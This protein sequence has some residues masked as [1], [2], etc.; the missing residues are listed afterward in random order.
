MLFILRRQEM[1]KQHSHLGEAKWCKSTKDRKY[2]TMQKCQKTRM[3]HKKT[4]KYKIGVIS[5]TPKG[6]TVHVKCR[7][8]VYVNKYK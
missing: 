5:V 6:Y 8:R 4:T 2:T 1:R 3:G 7:T